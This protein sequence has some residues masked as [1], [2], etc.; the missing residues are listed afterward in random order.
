M[1]TTKIKN[2]LNFSRSGGTKSSK[3]FNTSGSASHSISIEEHDSQT[4]SYSS[5]VFSKQSSL[6][7]YDIDFE[8]LVKELVLPSLD[9]PLT[10]FKNK[11]QE[12]N[13]KGKPVLQTCKT[14]DTSVENKIK[15]TIIRANT[16]NK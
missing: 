14:I 5:P 4:S 8:K 6:N 11:N 13:A 10:S 9:E 7:S 1:H 3:R 12:T 15:Q 16:E 2:F